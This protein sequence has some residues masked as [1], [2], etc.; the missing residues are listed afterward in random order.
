MMARWGVVEPETKNNL[1]DGGLARQLLLIPEAPVLL[2]LLLIGWAYG[3]PPAVSVLAAL[4]ITVF[5]LRLLLIASASRQ[6]DR[7]R[8]GHAER[9]SG[10]ALR[11]YPWSADALLLRAQGCVLRGDDTQAE[12][13]LR[14]ALDLA[15]DS[16]MV[17]SALAG[18]LIE[19]GHFAAAREHAGIAFR[20]AAGTPYAVQHL[21]WLA[22]HVDGEPISALRVLSTIDPEK[23][24]PALAA[25]LLVALAETQLARGAVQPARASVGKIDL[26]LD[27]CPIP[28]QAELCYQIGRLKAMFG[29]ESRAYFRRSVALDPSGRYAHSAWRAA[30]DADDIPTTLVAS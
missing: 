20:Q 2:A 10:A 27:Q 1:R 12:E 11:I 7:G 22:L 30:M 23:L 4:T 8:Y 6:L 16:P 26:M 24:Q 18:V 29:G 25:P 14:R 13:L 17:H 21:A 3:F 5:I 9:L 15:P 28:Q 19:R